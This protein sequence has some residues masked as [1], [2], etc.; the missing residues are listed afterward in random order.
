MSTKFKQYCLKTKQ[1]EGE[2]TYF[3]LDQLLANED[4]VERKNL[5]GNRVYPGR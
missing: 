2:L 1:V 5:G 3:C 4:G